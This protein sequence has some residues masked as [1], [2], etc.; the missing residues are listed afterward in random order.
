M[1]KRSLSACSK[2]IP[3]VCLST[4]GRVYNA[5]SSICARVNTVMDC[6]VSRSDRPRPVARVLVPVAV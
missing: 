5:W 4:A 2:L 6:G 3:G 1:L